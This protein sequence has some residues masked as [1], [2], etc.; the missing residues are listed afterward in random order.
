[1]SKAEKGGKTAT[2]QGFSLVEIL[3]ALGLSALLATAVG[4][5][6]V[7]VKV[8]Q[9]SMYQK[10]EM[11]LLMTQ[12]R[13]FLR[14]E[15]NCTANLTGISIGETST[16]TYPVPTLNK[17][18]VV[19]NVGT[20][21]PQVIVAP[22]S[23]FP[24]QNGLQIKSLVLTYNGRA[25]ENQSNTTIIDTLKLTVNATLAGA[26][27]QQAVGGSSM[28]DS[29]TFNAVVGATSSTTAP[30][31]LI[32]CYGDSQDQGVKFSQDE[33]CFTSGA[34]SYFNPMTGQCESLCDA[35]SATSATCPAGQVPIPQNPCTS[36]GGSGTTASDAQ[37]AAPLAITT[38]V[39]NTCNCAWATGST[40]GICKICCSAF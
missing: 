11:R 6:L 34:G 31:S 3:I 26:N 29:L 32:E 28:T 8:T 36:V 30:T 38:L 19:S 14:N 40:V 15:T 23:Y 5:S 13:L 9:Q 21:T 1:V 24:D 18:S 12:L 33:I 37:V 17:V 16:W 20:L 35:G 10:E 2:I 22:G 25:A 7:R 27:G 39:G 4:G